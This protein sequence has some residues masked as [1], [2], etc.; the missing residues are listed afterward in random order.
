MSR[1]QNVPVGGDA[2]ASNPY[3]IDLP[4]E[5]DL[6][7]RQI[8]GWA[9]RQRMSWR[10]PTEIIT[11]ALYFF[12]DHWCDYGDDDDEDDHRPPDP[13]PPLPRP[14]DTTA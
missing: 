7:L 11:E 10:T 9:L 4:F 14:D 13:P 1:H 3:V 2:M 6:C 12:A 5:V 8:Q